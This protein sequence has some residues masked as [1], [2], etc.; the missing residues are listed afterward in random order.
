MSVKIGINGFGRIG[1][2]AFRSAINN[3]DVEFVGINYPTITPDYAAY[4]LRYDTV[5]GGFDGTIEYYDNGIIVN[6]KKIPIFKA[7]VPKDIP[8]QDCGAEYIIEST[9]KFL[10][11]EKS[12]GHLEAGA[13][14]VVLSAPPKDDG[15]MFVMGVNHQDYKPSDHHIVSNASCTTNCL[16]PL[17]KIVH[18]NFGMLSGLMTTIHA[19]TSSQRTVDGRSNKDPRSGRAASGN[20]I[21]ASTGAAKSVGKVIPE[22]K[23]KLTG[24]ALRVPTLTVSVVDMTAN[25]EKAASYQEVC[26]AIKAASEGPMKGIVGYV[27][28]YVVSSDFIT[29]PRTCIFDAKA[30]IALNDHFMK[31]VAW[32]DNE[33]AYAAKIVELICYMA[34]MDK[35]T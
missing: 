15:P 31:L 19:L 22:L 5:H 21:P 26:A 33:Y 13:K 17:A 28:D 10:S 30:G 2:L 18:E 12:Q 4:L 14:K 35:N 20:I 34:K 16:A 11:A 32:Y 29:D 24:M 1:R 8:W 9:G 27:D 7:S 6:G 25:I 3:P 23:G